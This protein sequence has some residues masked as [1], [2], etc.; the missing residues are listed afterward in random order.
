MRQIET[1]G[2]RAKQQLLGLIDTFITAERARHG[3]KP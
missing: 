1:L 2:P 3:A